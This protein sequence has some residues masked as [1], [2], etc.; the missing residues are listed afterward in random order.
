M[1]T[2]EEALA[3]RRVKDVK[4]AH[5]LNAEFRGRFESLVQE[6]IDSEQARSLIETLIEQPLSAEE[7]LSDGILNLMLS[8]FVNGV[9][10][11][12]EM[13]KAE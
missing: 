10:V 6:I 4:H 12:I 1:K 7:T 8:A 3:T 2:F 5:R 11:G 13:E 9:I